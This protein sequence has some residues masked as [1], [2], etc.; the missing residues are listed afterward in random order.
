M[1]RERSVS[2][3][4]SIWRARCDALSSSRSPPVSRLP[5]RRGTLRS[6]LQALSAGG[7]GHGL[8]TGWPQGCQCFG[9]QGGRCMTV[10]LAPPADIKLA[11][12]LTSPGSRYA[13][14]HMI[15][16]PTHA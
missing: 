15:E 8:A 5:R 7:D 13:G 14:R 4:L 6:Y 12:S 2:V 9:D 10:L 3:I 1:S 11:R 16:R